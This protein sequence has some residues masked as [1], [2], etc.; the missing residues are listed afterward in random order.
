MNG[1]LGASL[2]FEILVELL[3]KLGLDVLQGSG[4]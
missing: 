2:Y 4:R 1:K 3:T